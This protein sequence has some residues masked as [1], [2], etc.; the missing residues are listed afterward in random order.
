MNL[1]APFLGAFFFLKEMFPYYSLYCSL[2]YYHEVF[3]VGGT[4]NIAYLL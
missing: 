1:T 2:Y 3:F 4:N